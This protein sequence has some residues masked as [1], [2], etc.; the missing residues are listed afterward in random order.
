M[1]ANNFFYQRLHLFIAAVEIVGKKWRSWIG[2]LLGVFSGLGYMALSLIAF[3]FRHWRTIQLVLGLV[4]V[5]FLLVFPFIPE[6][7]RFVSFFNRFL[8]RIIGDCG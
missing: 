5:P 6:S 3:F 4:F 7:P 2:L 8:S 1:T